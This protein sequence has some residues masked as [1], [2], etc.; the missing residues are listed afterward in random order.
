MSRH[1]ETVRKLVA[2]FADLTEL[3]QRTG[4]EV[5]VG[6]RRSS[7]DL[8]TVQMTL[9]IKP[10]K[11]ESGV[12]GTYEIA[13]KP[14][15]GTGDMFELFNF[16]IVPG[17]GSY[18]TDLATPELQ[19][20]FERWIGRCIEWR[21]AEK[22]R[23]FFGTLAET[24]RSDGKALVLPDLHAT[25]EA[26]KLSLNQYMQEWISSTSLREDFFA[27]FL[28][29]KKVRRHAEETEAE[30]KARAEKILAKF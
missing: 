3:L 11:T 5:S 4:M 20:E 7:E 21:I 24:P 13:R 23:Q 30:C 2:F 29:T 22:A 16:T 6:N 1:K 15:H 10:L 9:I 14:V 17:F 19:K 8:G 18:G 25:V 26:I 27:E 12:T 28:E